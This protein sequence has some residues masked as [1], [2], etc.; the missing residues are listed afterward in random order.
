MC[1][2]V[3]IARNLAASFVAGQFESDAIVER[4]AQLLGRR[5]RW[6]RPLAIRVIEKFSKGPRPSHASVVQFILRDHGFIRAYEKHNLQLI[7]LIGEATEMSPIKKAQ[8]W[9][10]PIINNI[11]ELADWLGITMGHL[12][13]FADLNSLEYKCNRGRLRHYH[14]RPL[15]KRFGSVRLIEAPKARLKEIQRKIL[16]GLLD[17]IPAHE[18]AHGFQRKRSVKTFAACHVGKSVVLRMDLHDFFPSITL[19]RVRAV[20]RSTGYHESV[21]D[22][23]AGLCTNCAPLDVWENLVPSGPGRQSIMLYSQPHLP[24]GAPTS[25]ALANLIAYRLDCRLSALAHSAGAVYTRYADDCAFSGGPEFFRIVK[26]FA[27]HVGA[28]VMDE[29]FSVN[30]RK[31][32]IMREGVRQKLAGLVVNE[33]TNFPRA[34]YDRLKAT[35]VNSIKHGPESQNRTQHRDFRAHLLGRISFIE[36]LNPN[37]GRKLRQLFQGIAW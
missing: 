14:Y 22:L 18:A 9:T 13:W 34:D 12:E 36:M 21:S 31:T 26:R 29:G 19:S 25:P 7:D 35:L 23:L 16:S 10:V 1:S 37:R 15:A 11:A 4:G 6:L 24:Q 8:P 3:S 30:F 27:C 5:W 28:V 33:K 2:Y 17:Q 32:R 20:F